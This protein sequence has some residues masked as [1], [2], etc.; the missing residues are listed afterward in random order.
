MLDSLKNQTFYNWEL[1]VADDASKDKSVDI[2]NS[3][4][5]N[6]KVSAKKI[7]HDNNKGLATVLNKAV[8]IC[9][10]E[11]IKIIAADDY[12]HSE[13]LKKCINFLV[14]KGESYGMVFTD[15]FAVSEENKLLPDI[16]DYNSLANL[17]PIYFNEMLLFGNRIAGLTVLIRKKVLIETGK[18]DIKFLIEDYYRW[19][20]ISEKYL[21]A[22][23]PKKLTYYRLHEENISKIKAERIGLEANFLPLLFDKKGHLKTKIDNYIQELYL[24]KKKIPMYL[25]KIYFSY[26][27]A[28]HTLKFCI[29][30]KI[31]SLFYRAFFSL[32]VR[33]GYKF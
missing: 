16:A 25:L 2:F 6:N 15:T 18:Y 11:F 20:K 32:S 17:D 28:K 9:D 23:I 22:Y 8:E 29:K 24:N 30:N 26:P 21:I 10:G 33:L 1:I 5:L 14:E 19:L 3:W 31:P 4:L 27:Y 13:Y 12:L 7:Y